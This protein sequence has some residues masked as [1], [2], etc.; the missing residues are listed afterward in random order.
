MPKGVFIALDGLDGAGKSTQCRLLADWLRACGHEV[1]TCRDPGGT[2]MGD[3]IRFI[4]LDGKNEMGL[5]C[6]ALLYMASR[7][8]LVEEIIRPALEAGNV[9]VSDRY[10]LANVA[11]QGHA[12]VLGA[13]TIWKLGELSAQGLLPDVTLLLDIGY[14]SASA[15]KSGPLDRLERRGLDYFAKVR[16]GFLEEAERRPA[17]IKVIDA[18]QPEEV[19]HERIRREVALVLDQRGRP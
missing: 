15:R 18:T 7:A 16:T 6:E 14:V 13:E 10:L 8:Q 19:V 4:L 3:R 11:Y 1:V 5:A 9:V 12:G 17:T 2:A